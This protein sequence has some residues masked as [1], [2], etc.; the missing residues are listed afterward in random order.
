MKTIRREKEEGI[1]DGEKERRAKGWREKKEEKR[2]RWAEEEDKT[3]ISRR[4]EGEGKG[5]GREG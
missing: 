5:E 4:N 2:K 1:R 3:D